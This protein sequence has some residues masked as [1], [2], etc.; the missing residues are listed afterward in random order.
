MVEQDDHVVHYE[1]EMLSE[2][3]VFMRFL[4]IVSDSAALAAYSN[5]EEPSLD[6]IFCL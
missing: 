4:K 3:S 6:W 2:Q 1:K 5:S